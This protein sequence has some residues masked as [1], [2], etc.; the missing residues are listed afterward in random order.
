[1]QH[2]ESFYPVDL[3]APITTHSKKEFMTRRSAAMLKSL[4][5]WS[6]WDF[7]AQ[8]SF[9]FT[10][11]KIP[12]V[13]VFVGLLANGATYTAAWLLGFAIFLDIVDGLIFK[14]SKQTKSRLI[15]MGRRVSDAVLDRLLSIGALTSAT[16]FLDMT[17]VPLMFIL[18]REC[19][20]F[21]VCGRPF[22][23]EGKVGHPNIMSRA[24]MLI[25]GIVTIMFI[26]T[27]SLPSALVIASFVFLVIG[28]A[29]YISRY[30]SN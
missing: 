27:S 4:A 21:F 6:H 18:A 1:M 14:M 5:G 24:G 20:L 11:A 26:A 25:L 16:I 9:A 23:Y 8:L 19:V 2:L 29:Q 17:I 7:A 12:I 3:R 28:T 13:I 22:L 10:Y 30:S 15:S